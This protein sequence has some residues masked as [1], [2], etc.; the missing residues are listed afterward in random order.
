MM[1]GLSPTCLRVATIAGGELT[2]VNCTPLEPGDWDQAWSQGLT[3]L[4]GHLSSAVKALGIRRGTAARV[5][6]IGPKAGA[7]MFNLPAHGPTALRAAELSLR[8]MLPERADTWPVAVQ[9]LH[10]DAATEPKDTGEPGEPGRTHVLGIS[11]SAPGSNTVAA[12]LRRAALG[13]D[14][15]IPL[16]AAALGLVVRAATSLPATGAYAVLWMGD[17]VTA[18]AGWYNG[19]LAF[20]RAIDFGYSLLADAFYRGARAQGHQTF[21]RLQGYR[22]LFNGGFPRRGQSVDPALLL[23]AEHVL[24]FVQPVVQRYVV[25]TRQTLRFSIPESELSRTTLVL[26]GPGSHIPE[27]ARSFEPQFDLAIERLD[28]Q[29][30]TAEVALERAELPEIARLNPATFRILPPMEA[31]RRMSAHLNSAIRTGAAVAVLGLAALAGSTYARTAKTVREL[32][33]LE[34]RTDAMSQH[35]VTRE[36]AERLAADL[37]NATKTIKDALGDRPRWIAGLSLVSKA[38]GESIELNHVS[39][40]FPAESGGAP[41]LMLNGVAWPSRNP[42]VK[43]DSLGAF[44]GRLAGSP[45]VSSAKIVS[46]LSDVNGGEAKTFVISVQLKALTADAVLATARASNTARA[47]QEGETVQAQ[48][49]PP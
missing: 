46:T 49:T 16:K 9:Q 44:L 3:P 33:N 6:Y 5:A 36:R 24:P 32:Q 21:A 26:A 22:L 47:R 25:E 10:R 1:I 19:R 20:A 37:S 17:H 13:V 14:G 18:L 31:N 12:W 38:C 2:R 28:K 4:D 11:D 23:S 43:T 39:G 27:A 7:E 8:E 34:A 42:N 48:E 45:L 30:V 40:S 41:I 15:L 35:A 29:P